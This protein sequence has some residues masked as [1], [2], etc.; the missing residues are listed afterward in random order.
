MCLLAA[1]IRYDK[2]SEFIDGLRDNFHVE[3][4]E[5]K[6]DSVRIFKLTRRGAEVREDL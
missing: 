5:N 6:G 4:V 3:V 1:K 2:D